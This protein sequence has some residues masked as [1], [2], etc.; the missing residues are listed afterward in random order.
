MDVEMVDTAALRTKVVA[1]FGI[2]LLID[3]GDHTD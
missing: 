2:A 1:T 3:W